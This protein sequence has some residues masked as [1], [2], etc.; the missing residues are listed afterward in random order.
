MNK[1]FLFIL[2]LSLIS[3]S[4]NAGSYEDFK[5]KKEPTV[6]E[7]RADYINKINI[8]IKEYKSYKGSLY[9]NRMES[10]KSCLKRADTKNELEICIPRSMK[11]KK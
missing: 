11:P 1:I 2:S 7:I 3:F 6:D 4:L 9:K 5:K 10:I 8:K